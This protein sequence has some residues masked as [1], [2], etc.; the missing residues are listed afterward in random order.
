[1]GLGLGLFGDLLNA[2]LRDNRNG[3][4]IYMYEYI[5]VCFA[6]YHSVYICIIECVCVPTPWGRI[7]A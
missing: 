5:C 1:M 2:R 4:I 3:T 7:G 6:A